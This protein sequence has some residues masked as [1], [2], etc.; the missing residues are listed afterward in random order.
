MVLSLVH[1]NQNDSIL[2]LLA[3]LRH[4]GILDIFQSLRL[5]TSIAIEFSAP[6]PNSAASFAL[7]RV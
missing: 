2:R 5:H 3:S 1:I 7:Q 6:I 4:V